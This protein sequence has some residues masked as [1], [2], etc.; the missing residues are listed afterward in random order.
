[1]AAGAT[2]PFGPRK[3]PT[4]A[5]ITSSSGRSRVR[6]V[7]TNQELSGEARIETA[8]KPSQAHGKFRPVRR[9]SYPEGYGC[10]CADQN[11]VAFPGGPTPAKRPIPLKRGPGAQGKHDGAE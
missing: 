1:M 9:R 3:R 6:P 4:K 5:D 11:A 2:A 10:Y 7:H 8:S